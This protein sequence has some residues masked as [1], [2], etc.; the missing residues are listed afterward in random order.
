VAHHLDIDVVGNVRGEHRHELTARGRRGRRLVAAVLLVIGGF[1]HPVITAQ[2]AE[3]AAP[4]TIT[5]APRSPLVYLEGPIDAGAPKRLAEAL[6]GIEGPAT[7]WLNSPGG[8][9]FAGMQLGRL[10]REQGAS[11][12][13]IDGRTLFP[14]E[15]YSACALAFLGGVHRFVDN[16]ARYGVHRASLPADR[17]TGE[18]D[19]ASQ[20][21][22]AIGSYVREMGI[23]AR[24]LILWTSAAPGEMYVLSPRE[25][26]E[27]RV[28]NDGG[29]PPAW[30]ITPF[31][32]GTMLQGRQATADGKGTVFFSCDGKQT[33]FGSVH[34]AAGES[35]SA[36]VQGWRHVITIDGD[37]RIPVKPLG[38]SSKNGVVRSTFILPP[39][40]VRRA[41][42]AKRIGH[43]M[44]PS[45]PAPAI[46][47][48]VDIGEHAASLV[49]TFL[50]RCL[51]PANQPPGSGKRRR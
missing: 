19:L 17:A 46:G 24:L 27:L 48:G 23:D 47:V 13:I 6:G 2:A 1:W 45:N 15:C 7:V 26:R 49:R 44:M 42:S 33:V 34:E 9:L 51:A 25:A 29:E 3:P 30:S 39:D 14:G 11:T 36:S 41:M 43:L 50:D 40:L 37:E 16:G 21:S 18:R 8:N 4:M 20:L 5:V 12:H 22:T 10:I 28:V 32:G 38:V 31:P 35:A